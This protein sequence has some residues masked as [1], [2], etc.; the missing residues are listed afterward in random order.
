MDTPVYA[1]SKTDKFYLDYGF[2][3]NDEDLIDENSKTCSEYNVNCFPSVMV[4]E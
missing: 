3:Y 4:F 1:I 2:K